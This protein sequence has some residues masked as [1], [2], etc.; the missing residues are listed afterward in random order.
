MDKRFTEIFRKLSK[1][2]HGDDAVDRLNYATTAKFLS[3][4]AMIL[5]TKQAIGQPLQCF[6]PAEYTKT[7][8][9]YIE[10]Y[11]FVENTYF[12]NASS[13]TFPDDPSVRQNYELKYYQW[14]PYI[15][16]F[17]A[18]ICY[19][20][21]MIFKILYSWSDVR[22]TDIIQYAWQKVKNSKTGK[23]MPKVCDTEEL[24][25]TIAEKLIVAK[26]KESR[27]VFVSYLTTIY[28]LMKFCALL[29]IILQLQ[30]LQ[31]FINADSVFWGFGLLKDLTSGSDWRVNGYFPRVTFCDLQTRDLGQQR[32]HTIQ[33]V[34]MLN[35]FIEK[36]YL[37]LWAWFLFTFV[38]TVVNILWW[39]SKVV[40]IN[41][42][43][44]M[45]NDALAQSGVEDRDARDIKEFIVKYLR[46]DG[47]VVLKL[48]EA[49]VGYIMMSD[50]CKRLWENYFQITNKSK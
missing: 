22:V 23:E 38:L 25:N 30:I 17:E 48:I 13:K 37:F 19:I 50:V 3:V 46:S 49:N 4:F 12:V 10:S 44:K 26:T 14:M 18:I 7:W 32:P 35:M 33:C 36:I 21:K 6:I 16:L 20:P 47:I 2:D 31:F 28:F 34:L 8:E 39:A 5:V 27:V 43:V 9:K 42:R 45:I 11:C 40:F 15:F 29:A 1:K 24:C 41:R